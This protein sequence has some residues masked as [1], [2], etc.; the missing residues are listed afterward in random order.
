[1]SNDLKLKRCPL[2]GGSGR[3][4]TDWKTG[5]AGKFGN[6]VQ[7]RKCGCR[8]QSHSTMFDAVRDWNEEN[9]SKQG[10]FNLSLFE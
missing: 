4:L 2:C 7:C 10:T 3:I 1:M 6:Y 9:V 5:F 8:T